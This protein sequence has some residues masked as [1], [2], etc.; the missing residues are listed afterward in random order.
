MTT[1]PRTNLDCNG[2]SSGP[3][4]YVYISHAYHCFAVHTM[5]YLTSW[6]K[7]AI[8]LRY[9]LYYLGL[10][11]FLM[12]W[13]GPICIICTVMPLTFTEFVEDLLDMKVDNMHH[14]SAI[15]SYLVS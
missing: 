11:V 8:L 3:C 12:W 5:R 2:K 10:E 6:P 4:N 7:L 1:E 13:V 14:F 9:L 15:L